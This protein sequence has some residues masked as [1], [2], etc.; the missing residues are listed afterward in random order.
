MPTHPTNTVQG[1][2]L[3]TSSAGDLCYLDH[4]MCTQV[5]PAVLELVETIT[6]HIN[7]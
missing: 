2:L 4:G 3:R 1:N 6:H 5:R 7:T